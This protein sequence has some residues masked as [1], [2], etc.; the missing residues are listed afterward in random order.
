MVVAA[1]PA[2]ALGALVEALAQF[3]V[4]AFALTGGI[5]F[6]V[7]VEPRHTQDFDLCARIT[8]DAAERLA[9]RFDGQPIGGGS[10][11]SIV[12]FEVAGWQVDLF[13]ALTAYDDE[14]LARAERIELLGHVV[15]VVRPEDLI[16][17]KLLKLQD[18]KRRLA[19]DAADLTALL[20]LDALD[21]GHLERW[22]PSVRGDFLHRGEPLPLDVLIRH[23]Q[24]LR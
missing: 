12:R 17:H 8:R 14:C 2:A 11:P 7:W 21:W 13:A 18:D 6:G 16:L 19:Q 4:S 10:V 23:L 24:A 15:P 5:A 20:A 1:E 22:L 3:H 9:A